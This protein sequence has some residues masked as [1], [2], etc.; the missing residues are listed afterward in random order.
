TRG[1]QNEA[2]WNRMAIGD[3]VLCVHGNTYRYAA[4]VFG[5]FK[6]ATCAKAI[7]GVDADGN[8]WEYLY[9]LSKPVVL[10]RTVAELGA[11]LNQG[12]QGFTRIGD[13]KVERL[14]KTYGALQAFVDERLVNA[15][16]I[17][18]LLRSNAGS[19]WQDQDAESYHYGTTDPNYTKLVS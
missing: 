18:L 11:E 1:P 8:T 15:P 5:K 2:R 3:W 13:E 10:N 6:N 14:I 4:Q 7:W 9:F 17:Y 19:K 16:S 12:Y